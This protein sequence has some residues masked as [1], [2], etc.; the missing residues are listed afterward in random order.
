MVPR[1]IMISTCTAAVHK[2]TSAAVQRN[3]SVAMTAMQYIAM[4]RP[5][6]TQPALKG[7]LPLQFPPL[8]PPLH[9]HRVGVLVLSS[10]HPALP[11]NLPAPLPLTCTGSAYLCFTKRSE[12]MTSPL[13]TRYWICDMPAP[14]ISTL[15]LPVRSPDRD[16]FLT[17]V[18][19]RQAGR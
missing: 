2:N 10:P 3:I 12:M 11:S 18:S 9:L 4:Q 1:R 13:T 7:Q 15:M 14:P 5:K 16:E 19:G 17:S 6:L 8:T